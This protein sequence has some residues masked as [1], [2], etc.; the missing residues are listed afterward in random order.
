MGVWDSHCPLPPTSPGNPPPPRRPCRCTLLYRARNLLGSAWAPFWGAR[1]HP[2][3]S[4]E[5]T[6]W[7]RN[8]PQL[9][10]G[11]HGLARRGTA[12]QTVKMA[13]TWAARGLGSR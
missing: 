7:A 9:G 1:Q 5:G 4:R 3:Q 10:A 12:W 11:Q 8:L 6:R 2:V 13:L